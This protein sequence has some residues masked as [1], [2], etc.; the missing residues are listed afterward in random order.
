MRLRRIVAAPCRIVGENHVQPMRIAAGQQ[1]DVRQY[2]I[3]ACELLRQSEIGEWPCIGDKHPGDLIFE[4]PTRRDTSSRAC[5][6][7]SV[8]IFHAPR[9]ITLPITFSAE[10][11]PGPSP[12]LGVIAT[13][14]R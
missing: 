3:G 5:A 7:A 2:V 13:R 12:Y 8:L 1:F 6:V 9:W 4:G 10:S 14:S 11:V